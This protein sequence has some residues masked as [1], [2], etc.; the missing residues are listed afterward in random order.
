M[1]P[2]SHGPLERSRCPMSMKS[3]RTSLEWV[4]TNILDGPDL[5]TMYTCDLGIAQ[6]RGLIVLHSWKFYNCS[7][8]HHAITR[9]GKSCETSQINSETKRFSLQDQRKSQKL[10][11]HT[12]LDNQ[13]T[14]GSFASR[15]KCEV[16]W[17]SEEEETSEILS[18]L[19]R[20]QSAH[21]ILDLFHEPLA[22]QCPAVDACA[23]VAFGGFLKEFHTISTC[24]WKSGS[25]SFVPL[26]A[27]GHLFGVCFAG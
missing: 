10:H 6:D 1:P 24:P 21:E 19:T 26:A 3:P 27:G 16:Q 7:V 18:L 13:P 12:V 5:D 11:T 2:V 15:S 25:C 23:C 8:Q 17:R 22:C 20:A 14:F 9:N 4:T